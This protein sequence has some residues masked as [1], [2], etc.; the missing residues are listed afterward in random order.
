MTSMQNSGSQAIGSRAP[1]HDELMASID[2]EMKQGDY[3]ELLTQIALA[4]KELTDA[5][6]AA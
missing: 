4:Y 2:R 1:D 6:A 5:L 3:V